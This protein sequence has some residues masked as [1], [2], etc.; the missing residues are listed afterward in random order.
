MPG[1]VPMRRQ[2]GLSDVC[3]GGGGTLRACTA[4]C[5][6]RR[7]SS[8]N[9]RLEQTERLTPRY[10]SGKMHRRIDY[11]G[12]DSIWMSI[13]KSEMMKFIIDTWPFGIREEKAGKGSARRSRWI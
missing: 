3:A 7:E 10:I 4:G 1:L 8:M 9:D 5:A 6:K 13:R 11:R 12:T 2:L